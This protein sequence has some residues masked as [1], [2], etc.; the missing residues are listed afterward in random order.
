MWRV[1]DEGTF[2]LCE[3]FL[4]GPV[5]VRD[6]GY[7]LFSDPN[8][9]NIYRWTR[10]GAISIYRTKSGY[11]GLD[12]G[13]YHQPGSNGLAIDREGRISFDQHDDRR[14]IRV[15]RTGAVTV[16]ADRFEGK[17]LNSPN[18]LVYRSDGS[19]Y[20]TDPPFGLPKVFDDSAKDTP[21]SGVYL[22]RDGKVTLLTKELSGPNGLAFSPDERFF[23]V[24]TWDPKHK[25]IMRY[26]VAADGTLR[27]RKVFY[28]ITR[29]EPGDDAWDGIKVDQ[30][31][32]VYAAGPRGIYVLN[33]DGK[34]LGLITPPEHVANF[35]WG[36]DDGRAL[37]ITA[38]TG[39]YRIR[40]SV[41][42][43]GAFAPVEWARK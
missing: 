29:T 35:A 5:W 12:I 41:S 34:L 10:D 8:A 27:N 37:Y 30:M 40:L 21:W 2:T 38:S 33:P 32:N 4:E 15:E 39:L 14:V 22:V 17:R 28:D 42:G 31:G 6:G 1:H 20:V 23:Y 36:D 9:N 25:V 11:A 24:D 7:L 18:D 13:E 3:E 26:E 16:L 43:T 19:L